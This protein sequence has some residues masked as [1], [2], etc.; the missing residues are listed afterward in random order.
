MNYPIDTIRSRFPALHQADEHGQLPILLDG[1]GGSQVPQ[2]VL[3]A[4]LGYLGR[5]NSNL[6]GHAEAGRRTQATNEQARA[7]AA[8]WLGCAADEIVFGLNSTSLMFN[9]S[10]AVAQTWQPGDNIVLSSLDHYSHVSSWQRA[11]ED[12]GVEVR[13]LPLN[14]EGS[15]LDYAA[16][17][18]LLDARTRLLAFT[19]ASNVLGTFS[20]APSLVRAARAAGA[21]VSVDAVHAAVHRLPDVKALDCDFLFASAYKLGGPHLGMCYGKRQHWQN[22]RPYKVEP[23]AETVPNRWEQ[24]TQSFEAQAGFTAMVDYWAGLGGGAGSRRERLQAAYRQVAAYEQDLNRVVLHGLAER[25]YVRLYGLPAAE[26]R[27]PTFAFNIV[28][29]GRV[30]PAAPVSQW[31]GRRN[32]ALGNGNFYA[33][34]VSR[35][36]GLGDEGFLRIGCLHYTSHTE[37][38]RFFALLDQ[39]VAELGYR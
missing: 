23:A 39:C 22:L 4:L 38:E 1:P 24:G 28:Q 15:D 36:L 7:A 3:D 13:I 21:W 16:L 11:A 26:G 8:D 20:Q 6:G 17:P 10:R 18:G 12:M 34:A 32:V 33:L 14:A 19:L 2:C 25:P 5:Y 35:H 29:N 37:I 30:Q 9:L 27:S 31:F